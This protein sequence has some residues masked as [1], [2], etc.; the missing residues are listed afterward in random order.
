MNESGYALIGVTVLVAVLAAIVTFALLRFI[1]AARETRSPRR[2]GNPETAL[3]SAALQEAVT[4]LKAQ[5][6]EMTARAAASEE[7][8]GQIVDSLTSGLLVVDRSGRVEMMNLAARR[9][10]GVTRGA[11]GSDYHQVL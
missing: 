5:E 1:A 10:L 4:K 8:S 2:G 11:A 3:L 7:L 9:M 6:L